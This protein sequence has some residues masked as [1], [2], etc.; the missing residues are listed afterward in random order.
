ME[1]KGAGGDHPKYLP[2]TA[3]LSLSSL[4]FSPHREV[5]LASEGIPEKM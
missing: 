4:V 2:A 5:A 3:L 1:A